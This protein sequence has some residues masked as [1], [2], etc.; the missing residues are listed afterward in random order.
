MFVTHQTSAYS[1]RQSHH[2]SITYIIVDHYFIIICFL[3]DSTKTILKALY[4]VYLTHAYML[5]H[6]IRCITHPIMN[7]S[8]T[9]HP[10]YSIPRGWWRHSTDW[11][12][13]RCFLS[14]QV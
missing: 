2:C 1:D 12:R 9:I 10:K 3:I 5:T 13:Y 14:L 8:K 7:F 6:P 4:T 11:V